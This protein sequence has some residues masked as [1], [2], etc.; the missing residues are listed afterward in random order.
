[1]SIFSQKLCG[2]VENASMKVATLSRLSGVERSYIQKMLSGER[3]PKEYSILLRLAEALMLTPAESSSLRDAYEISKMGES[4]YSRH[5][6]VKDLLEEADRYLPPAIPSKPSPPRPPHKELPDLMPLEGRIAISDALQS[7]L[8]EETSAPEAHLCAVIQPDC[9]A[10]SQIQIYCLMNP[11][12]RLEHIVCFDRNQPSQENQHYNLRCMRALLPF[13]LVSY[14]YSGWFY[15]D[16]IS[17]QSSRTSVF[18]WFILGKNAV[19]SLSRDCEKAIL[20]TQPQ[21]V[22]LFRRIFEEFRGACSPLFEL[23]NTTQSRF[24]NSSRWTEIQKQMTYS[25]QFEPCWGFFYT[26]DMIEKSM[27]PDLPNREQILSFFADRQKQIT[28][29]EDSQRKNTSFFTPEGID[30]FLTTGKTSEIP[31]ALYTPL[32]VSARAELL[33]RMLRCVEQGNYTPYL[34]RSQKLTLPRLLSL[35]ITDE[36]RLSCSSAHPVFGLYSVIFRE[37]SI[38]FS[39]RDFLEYLKDTDMVYS[40]EESVTILQNKLKEL[41][42][43]EAEPAPS[44][45]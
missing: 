37:K 10:I 16:S 35:F 18:P 12:L 8:A 11:K 27:L 17:A 32:P 14:Q 31:E 38:V 36:Q 34:V 5:M 9:M 2:Y 43:L 21:A 29:L 26:M 6:A 41:E 23:E 45:S 22:A 25:I 30:R 33:R 39:I 19:F 3:L 42:R 13:L 40:R 28:L 20:Y 4:V 24:W 44:A 15:Y 1:M 7:F